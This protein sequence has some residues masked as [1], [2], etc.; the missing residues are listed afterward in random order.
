MNAIGRPVG[1]VVSALWSAKGTRSGGGS[2]Y[3]VMPSRGVQPSGLGRF[4]AC[5]LISCECGIMYI[6]WTSETLKH[7]LR[8]KGE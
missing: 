5:G 4:L 7:T 8:G 3:L 2:I 6:V 1:G